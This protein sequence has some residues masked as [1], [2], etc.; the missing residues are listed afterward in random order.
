MCGL[1]KTVPISGS[2]TKLVPDEL[3]VTVV[4]VCALAGEPGWWTKREQTSHSGQMSV[5][6][7]LPQAA[8]A[9]TMAA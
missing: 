3:R 5:M 9:F 6:W 7:A 2:L 8:D 4:H 1:G